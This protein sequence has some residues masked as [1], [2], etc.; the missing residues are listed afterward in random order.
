MYSMAYPLAVLA[1]CVASANAFMATGPVLR[2]SPAPAISRAKLGSVRMTAAAPTEVLLLPS[3]AMPR[4]SC[5]CPP[6]HGC[7]QCPRACAPPSP[8]LCLRACACKRA[9]P[10]APWL[11]RAPGAMPGCAVPSLN[12]RSVASVCCPRGVCAVLVPFMS[13]RFICMR[14]RNRRCLAYSCEIANMMWDL[15]LTCAPS[16]SCTYCRCPCAHLAF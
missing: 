2:A 8:R 12:S 3:L 13:A 9:F 1:T 16:N 6:M 11:A 5:D 7:M 15:S 14:V 4:C 10:C